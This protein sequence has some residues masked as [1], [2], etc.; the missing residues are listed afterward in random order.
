MQ[1]KTKLREAVAVSSDAG[2][3]GAAAEI[4]EIEIRTSTENIL[5]RGALRVMLRFSR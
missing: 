1:V 5:M 2:N 3:A 4:V